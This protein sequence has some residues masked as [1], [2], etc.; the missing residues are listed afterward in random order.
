MVHEAIFRRWDKLRDWIAAEREFLAWKTGL[1]I[2]K[3]LPYVLNVSEDQAGAQGRV[4]VTVSVVVCCA[5]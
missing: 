2:A 4:A 1:E 3:V 5:K